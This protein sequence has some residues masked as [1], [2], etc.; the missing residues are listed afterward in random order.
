MILLLAHHLADHLAGPLDDPTLWPSRDLAL[1][2]RN[3]R[4]A[5]PHE[6]HIFIL[7][8]IGSQRLAR[9]RRSSSR[10]PGLAVS[11]RLRSVGVVLSSL[12]VERIE[13]VGVE[14][15]CVG[16]LRSLSAQQIIHTLV[17]SRE[18][19]FV[20]ASADV[21]GDGNHV[22]VELGILAECATVTQPIHQNIN[23]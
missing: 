17:H 9:V 15:A 23:V 20:R 1:N 4:R 11:V 8:V 18:L 2:S 10:P 3:N 16:I 14:V 22:H 19:A 7:R 12:L 21:A 6:A 5:D 13:G